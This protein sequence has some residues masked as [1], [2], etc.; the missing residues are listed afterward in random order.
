[1]K[2]PR[3]PTE[4]QPDVSIAAKKLTQPIVLTSVNNLVKGCHCSISRDAKQLLM[5]NA[6]DIVTY[7]VEQQRLYQI[8]KQ[9]DLQL[10]GMRIRL[11]KSWIDKKLGE[12][13]VPRIDRSK[14]AQSVAAALTMIVSN[15]C[16]A[17]KTLRVKSKSPI[18]SADLMQHFIRCFV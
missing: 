13:E 3:V 4:P 1:M 14:Y 7:V 15:S 12:L 2:L 9:T 6:A 11:T 18:V 8:P 10:G 17:T 16:N 5:D